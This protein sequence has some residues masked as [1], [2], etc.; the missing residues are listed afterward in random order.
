M[1]VG[2][3]QEMRTA[4]DGFA[5][6]DTFMLDG[7]GIIPPATPPPPATNFGVTLNSDLSMTFN[8]TAVDS[9]GT[10]SVRSMLVMRAGAPVTAAPTLAQAGQIGG[11]ANP[12]NFGTGVNL[13]GGNWMVFATAAGGPTNVTAT[14]KGLTPGV[15]YYSCVYT[16]VGSGGN[17][18]FNIVLPNGACTNKQ[19]GSLLSISTQPVPCI[20]LGGLQVLQVI[21]NFTGGAH[22]NVS[23]FATVTVADPTVIVTTNGAL[24]GLSIGCSTVTAVYGGFTNSVSACVCAPTFTDNFGVTHDYV[25]N[26]ANGS[27]WDGVYLNYGDVPE[28]TFNNGNPLVDGLTSYAEA[29]IMSNNVLT[30]TNVYG[31]WENENND[32]FFL[33]KYVPGDFQAAVHINYFDIVNYTFPGIGARAYSWG[34]NGTDVGSP[35]DLGFGTNGPV[36]GESW[37]NFTRFDEF[38]I[39]TYARLNL[40]NGVLQSTQSNPNNGDNWLLIIRDHGTNFNFYERATNN[41]PWRL[42][43]NRTSYA[44]PV[45]AGQPMQVGIQWMGFG[46]GTPAEAQFDHFMLNASL[47]TLNVTPLGNGTIALSWPAVPGVILQKTSNLTPPVTWL[48]VPGSPTLNAGIASLI[49]PDSGVPTFFR[50][51]R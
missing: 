33:F 43:P 26:R 42:T 49:L 45:F 34:T 2:L 38:G 30:V 24:T 41:A 13:G 36:N 19:D 10:N 16:F 15:V 27:P 40:D 4:S 7:P 39:G 21:G 8:W 20:P 51:V 50:L 29:N 32:G 47:A 44:V 5:P 14:V 1:E 9:T 28:S 3:L 31:G 37:V 6:L 22:V 35:F 17:K 46:G 48:N 11:T 12:V 18:S 23:P 25:A